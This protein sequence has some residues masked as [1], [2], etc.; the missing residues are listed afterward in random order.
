MTLVRGSAVFAAISGK[1]VPRSSLGAATGMQVYSAGGMFWSKKP[2]ILRNPPYTI[3]DP[4]D[5]QKEIRIEFGTLAQQA[6]GQRG[7][8]NGLPA[9]AAYIQ[10]HLSGYKAPDSMAKESYPSAKRHTIHTLNELKVM[11]KQQTGR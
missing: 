5:G 6:K 1:A 10:E 7:F 8:K 4:H 3:D 2:T 9:V 11:L